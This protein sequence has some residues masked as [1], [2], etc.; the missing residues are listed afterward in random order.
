MNWFKKSQQQNFLWKDDKELPYANTKSLKEYYDIK[1]PLAGNIVGGLTVRKNIDNTDSISA[2]LSNYYVYRGIREIPISDF[3]SGKSYNAYDNN[4]SKKL[5][6]KINIS[7]QIYPLIVIVDEEG[8]YILEG[9]HRLYAL[10]LLGIQSLPALL[11]LDQENEQ[12][13]IL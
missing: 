4:I 6:E 7:K 12:K 10:Q 3:G 13:D 9:G 11:V 8:P 2:S 5:T 1:Y